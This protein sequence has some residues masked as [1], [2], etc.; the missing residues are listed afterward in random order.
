MAEPVARLTVA[1]GRIFHS[2]SIYSKVHTRP[3]VPTVAQ[4]N[5]TT[6]GLAVAYQANNGLF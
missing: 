1:K 4:A 5:G 3:R 6:G 2:S